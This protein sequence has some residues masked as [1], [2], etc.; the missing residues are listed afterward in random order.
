MVK[1]GRPLSE[2]DLTE[3]LLTKIKN[4]KPIPGIGFSLEFDNRSDS[5]RAAKIRVRL[6]NPKPG[7]TGKTTFSFNA[8]P[9]G[10][11]QALNIVEEIKPVVAKVKTSKETGQIANKL[12]TDYTNLKKT[13]TDDL[14]NWI[15]TNAKD[16]KYKTKGGADKLSKDA[17]K[18]FNKG[19]YIEMPKT[20]ATGSDAWLK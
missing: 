17:F 2:V 13:Y 12:K 4:F 3:D 7:Y 14:V 15:K 10:Y 8:T 6:R 1:L 5:N 19:K 16:E 11:R 18:E 9:A 20:G